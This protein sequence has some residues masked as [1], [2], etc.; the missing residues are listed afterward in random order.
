ML[1]SKHLNENNIVNI[2]IPNICGEVVFQ[3]INWYILP[4]YL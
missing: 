4:I 3:N 1:I 2:E